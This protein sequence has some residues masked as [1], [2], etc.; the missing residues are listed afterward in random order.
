MKRRAWLFAALALLAVAAWLMSRGDSRARPR[1]E[2]KV[3]FPR[4]AKPEENARNNQRRTLPPKPPEKPTDEYRPRRDPVLTALPWTKGKSALVFEASALRDSPLGKLWLDCMLSKHDLAEMARFK[5]A[6]GVDVMQD[7]DRVAMSSERVGVV[8][9]TFSEAR[10]DT[11]ERSHRAYGVK[12]MIYEDREGQG[13]PLALWDK[14]ML[15]F[16]PKVEAIEAAIDRL[17]DRGPPSTPLLPEWAA[18]GD[19]YGLISAEDLS[20]LLPPSQ[21]EIAD[22][23]R[24]AVDKIELHVDASEDVG[25]VADVTGPN[26]EEVDDFGKSLGAALS[27]GRLKAQ[28]EGDDKLAQLMEL[29]KVAP[30]DGRFSVDLALPMPLIQQQLGPCPRDRDRRDKD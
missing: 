7:I 8:S 17:E 28:S 30:R 11:P 4:H 29:A 25:I 1:P 27:L 23:L 22:R 5:S 26:G 14:T 2:V 3:E 12:G 9:G 21:K 19:V 24:G 10:F 13:R 18:Y 6:Y 15:I 20:A 16:S